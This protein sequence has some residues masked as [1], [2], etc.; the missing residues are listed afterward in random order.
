MSWQG[1]TSQLCTCVFAS[2]CNSE[3]GLGCSLY[4]TAKG[5]IDCEVLLLLWPRGSTTVP[6]QLQ[7]A[8]Q[9]MCVCCKLQDTVQVTTHGDIQQLWLPHLAIQHWPPEQP[10]D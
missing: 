1:S 10:P 7:C 9:K 8:V 4:W 5:L 6:L 2:I 3:R